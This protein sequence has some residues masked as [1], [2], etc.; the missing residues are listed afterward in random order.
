MAN[1]VQVL[2]KINDFGKIN[3]D[4]LKKY[5]YNTMPLIHMHQV[6]DIRID[7]TTKYISLDDLIEYTSDNESDITLIYFDTSVGYAK[8]YELKYGVLASKKSILFGMDIE[9]KLV[10]DSK[11]VEDGFFKLLKNTINEVAEEE[12]SIPSVGDIIEINTIICSDSDVL[13]WY[14]CFSDKELKVTHIDYLS[15]NLYVENCE[16]GINLNEVNKIK[17]LA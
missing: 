15:Q 17:E 6:N 9:S 5:L 2:I 14:L 4:N 8:K 7:L 10:D 1:E 16:F 13:D 11:N 3:I 12:S